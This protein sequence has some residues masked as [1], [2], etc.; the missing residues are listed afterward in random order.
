VPDLRCRVDDLEAAAA[1]GQVVAD[2]E[3]GLPGTDDD[4]IER[5][6]G[7]GGDHGFSLSGEEWLTPTL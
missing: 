2:G 1:A 4:N 7:R 3:P 5:F 6:H